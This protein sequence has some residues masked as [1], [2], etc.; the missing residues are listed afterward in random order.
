MSYNAN[1]PKNFG[2]VRFKYDMRSDT[3]T[4]PTPEMITQMTLARVGDDV[5]GED[6][7]TYD[8]ECRMA[9]L[10]GK[11][12]G[13]FCVSGTLSNQLALRTHLV[14]P[15]YSV[16]C[17]ANSHINVYEAGG[18]AFHSRALTITVNPKNSKYITV[19]EVKKS[20]IYDDEDIHCAPT[21]VISLEN[22]INGVVV[23]IDELKK[24]HAFAK[25]NGAIMHLDGARLWNASVKSGVSFEEY[26]KYFDSM[27]ICFSKGMSAPIGSMLVVIIELLTN[28]IHL[29]RWRQSGFIAEAANFAID[30][31]L[32]LLKNDHERASNLASNL[33]EMGIKFDHPV[34]TNMV[35]ADFGSVGLN[36]F[37]VA[38]ELEKCGVLIMPYTDTVGRIVYHHMIDDGATE[39][40]TS[41]IKKLI[42]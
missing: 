7:S 4:R 40:I 30:N 32:P 8:L 28:Y 34:E 15:P 3:V 37:D 12:A 1:A 16:L 23:P 10:C 11:E 17:D 2:E 18:V 27:S 29:N 20:F 41:T 24:I 21:R 19:E 9:N 31:I 33:S 38:N 26:G 25:E 35:F 5:Y 36:T 13:L 39:I 22:T 42:K 6:A 14:A